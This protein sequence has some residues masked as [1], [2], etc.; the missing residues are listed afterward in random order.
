M[1]NASNQELDPQAQLLLDKIE[2][3]GIPPYYTM[4]PIE[5]RAYYERACE[6]ARG[7]PPEPV[8]VRDI[9]IPGPA[10]ILPARL[11]SAAS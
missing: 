9:T 4:T 8:E 1:L 6:V 7:E 5:A 10:S 2:A 3:S 11:Y